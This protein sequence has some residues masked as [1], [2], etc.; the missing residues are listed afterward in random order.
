GSAGLFQDIVISLG[1]AER[2]L[3]LTQGKF[4]KKS[5]TPIP[6]L[7]SN[8]VAAVDDRSKEFVIARALASVHDPE[9]KIGPLRANFEPVDWK[10]HCRNW[11]EKDRAVVWN[12]ADLVTNLGRVFERRLVD[13]ARTGC[14]RLPLA[15]HFTAPLD[16]VAAFIAGEIDDERIEKLI[17][18]L[19]LLSDNGIRRLRTTRADDIPV[20]RAY[21]LLKLLFLPRPLVIGRDADGALFARIQRNNESGG[22]VISVEPSIPHLL[23]AGRLGEACAIGM[24]RL[25]ASGLAPMPRPIR[26]RRVRDDD[27]RELD[28]MGGSGIDP[29]RL[30]AALPIP[31]GDDAVGRLVRLVIRSDDFVDDQTEAAFGA[32]FEGSTLS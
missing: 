16:A 10:Q 5:V 4:K 25:R 29:R 20:P 8:W 31:I 23:R 6:L 18:G 26:G 24:R 13:G 11:A 14:A 12:A 21:A 3:A 2:E 17:W 28:R 19:M 27:W 9:A 30:A 1:R 32:S 7:S 15:S 22:I